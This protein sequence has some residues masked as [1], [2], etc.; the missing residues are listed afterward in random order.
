MSIGSV[1]RRVGT[2]FIYDENGR[3]KGSIPVF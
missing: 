2:I 3:Q 1:V